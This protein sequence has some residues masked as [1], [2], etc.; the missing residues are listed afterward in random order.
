MVKLRIQ[1]N[2]YENFE[3]SFMSYLEDNSD[4][5]FIT[6][7]WNAIFKMNKDSYKVKYCGFFEK[8]IGRAQNGYREMVRWGEKTLAVP[9][10]TECDLCVIEGEK[11]KYYPFPHIGEM[12]VVHRTIL[13]GKYAF[14]ITTN[15]KNAVL[16]F[17]MEKD[18]IDIWIN[19][20][21][22]DMNEKIEKWLV[23]GIWQEENTIC[24]IIRNSN[25][26]VRVSTSEKKI[27]YYELKEKLS[28][29][30]IKMENA[31]WAVTKDRKRIVQIKDDNVIGEIDLTEYV[32]DYSFWGFV[33]NKGMLWL[34]PNNSEYII[35]IDLQKKERILLEYPNTFG[36]I[37]DFRYR[38]GCRFYCYSDYEKKIILYPRSG[39]GIL[40][41]D[42]NT[43]KMEHIPLTV[44]M[45]DIIDKQIEQIGAE[46]ITTWE[47]DLKGY[48]D[49]ITDRKTSS[50]IRVDEGTIWI[51]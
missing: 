22:C 32:Q 40:I 37:D 28:S 34:F 49:I 45:R 36:W 38:R 23:G 9:V 30:C 26:I 44:N 50:K 16:R 10:T 47:S 4:M 46:N 8:Y 13:V 20:R 15:E 11:K 2:N 21:Q 39:N 17:D 7:N 18:I 24:C 31:I 3:L 42:K 6:E 1:K 48:I 29:E 43:D 25:L 35:K 12:Y 14:I 27:D 33:L 51:Y 41:I 5:W 19:L